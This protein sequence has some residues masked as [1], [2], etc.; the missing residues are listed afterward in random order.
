MRPTMPN[1]VLAMASLCLCLWGRPARASH[2]TQLE[3]V[4]A[5]LINLMERAGHQFLTVDPSG[6]LGEA[7]RALHHNGRSIREEA[8]RRLAVCRADLPAL[9]QALQRG[10]ANPL[11]GLATTGLV[12]EMKRLAA[13][14]GA[15]G[16]TE[17]RV[18]MAYYFDV[19]VG[20]DKQLPERFRPCE[21]GLAPWMGAETLGTSDAQT[22][23][24]LCRPLHLLSSCAEE[25]HEL[26]LQ[27]YEARAQAEWRAKPA[28]HR[29]AIRA[30]LP[31]CREGCEAGDPA[32]CR[33]A[34]HQL[35]GGGS[36][37]AG[38]DRV[39]EARALYVLGCNSASRAGISERDRSE[40]MTACSELGDNY[41][42]GLRGF[43]KDPAE[44]VVWLR[45]ACD[46]GAKH[47]CGRLAQAERQA[48]ARVGRAAGTRASDG[49]RTSG[50]TTSSRRRPRRQTAHI[51]PARQA[52][53]KKHLRLAEEADAKATGHMVIAVLRIAGGVA[54]MGGGVAMLAAS[55]DA[56]LMGRGGGAIGGGLGLALT[57]DGFRDARTARGNAE[58]HRRK[59]AGLSWAPVL[60]SDRVALVVASSF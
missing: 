49:S 6:P 18:D 60:G 31:D 26:A 53:R 23:T 5:A 10:G 38:R 1:V 40:A 59:A 2:L 58:H 52:E 28:A 25:F 43:P 16:L 51:S 36:G 57:G 42:G 14:D 30:S 24:E 45:K 11:G 4:P 41:V 7:E 12:D 35:L 8:T 32:S 9:E 20:E 3:L 19:E 27:A 56:F 46:A 17:Y 39:D 34:G 21:R 44:G 29:C 33:T 50:R 37:S 22:L 55:D 48:G 13:P 15:R 54:L 47:T